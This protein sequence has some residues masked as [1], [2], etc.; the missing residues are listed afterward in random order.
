M[1]S[2]A[3]YE[4]KDAFTWDLLEKKTVEF[5]IDTKKEHLKNDIL[6]ELRKAY[7]LN[8]LPS[9][10]AMFYRLHKE[11]YLLGLQCQDYYLALQ[12]AY[13]LTLPKL[14]LFVDQPADPRGVVDLVNAALLFKHNVRRDE[15]AT[16][17]LGAC[18][19][20]LKCAIWRSIQSHGE[21]SAFRQTLVE[22]F[23]QVEQEVALRFQS[24]VA[25]DCSLAEKIVKIDFAHTAYGQ[26]F[27][28]S[29]Y[30]DSAAISAPS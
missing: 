17:F 3:S 21:R 9:H 22:I 5:S 2:K 28:Q 7:K 8:L 23:N 11:A 29:M 20:L 27:Q 25:E 24:K 1:C 10:N 18:Q 16:A 30:A 6:P 26:R 15:A 19:A 4:S 12:H 13:V 14:D